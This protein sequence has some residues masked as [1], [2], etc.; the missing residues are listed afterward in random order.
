M[1]NRR[2]DRPQPSPVHEPAQVPAR[3]E[4]PAIIPTQGS[5]LALQRT[6]GNRGTIELLQRQAAGQTLAPKPST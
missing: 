3:S 1:T 4:G 5:V 2:P 6:L